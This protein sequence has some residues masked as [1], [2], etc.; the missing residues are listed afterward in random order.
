M[1][2]CGGN[3]KVEDFDE[4]MNESLTDTQPNEKDKKEN[5]K[6]E[7]YIVMVTLDDKSLNFYATPDEEPVFNKKMFDKAEPF[8]DGVAKVGK[9]ID[10]SWLYTYIDEKGIEIFNYKYPGIGHF[11]DDIAWV[12]L[13]GKYG[14]IDKEGSEMIPIEYLNN[15][16]FNNGR[17]LISDKEYNQFFDINSGVKYGYMNK[18]GDTIIPMKYAWAKS[19]NSGY[20]PVFENGRVFFLDKNGKKVF[21]KTFDNADE[22]RNDIAPVVS[23]GKIGF[24]D[25]QGMYIVSPKYDDYQFIYN[26]NV[27]DFSSME[28][29]KERSKVYQTDEG[30][31]LVSKNKKWGAIDKDEKEIVPFQ[32]DGI[33]IPD[34]NI[35]EVNKIKRKKDYS[36]DYYTGLYDLYKKE[37]ILPAK[38]DK[39]SSFYKD[40]S[41]WYQI[42]RKTNPDDYSCDLYGFF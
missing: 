31:L 33:G 1:I 17:V 3:D 26:Y 2:G 6:P 9:K 10:S 5:Y 11:S 20:A 25:N 7:D 15:W 8:V 23:N 32:F 42:G 28:S 12:F 27:F 21:N 38:Y 39:V 30:Y 37:L 19:F 41:S 35:V 24:I 18:S 13:D 16:N 36:T 40:N 14:Y 34:S 29:D 4:L 22:F